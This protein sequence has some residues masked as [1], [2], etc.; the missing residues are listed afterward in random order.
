MAK[1][2]TT[3]KATKRPRNAADLTL[4]NLR[5]LRKD[6]LALTRRVEQLEHVRPTPPPPAADDKP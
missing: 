3:R 5:A 4:R 2:P 1:R 6:L